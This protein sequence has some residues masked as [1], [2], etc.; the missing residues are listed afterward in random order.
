MEDYLYRPL[1]SHKTFEPFEKSCQ[2]ALRKHVITVVFPKHL[3]DPCYQAFA[4]RFA[5]LLEEEV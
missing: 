2:T 4:D 5:A 1:N 3:K